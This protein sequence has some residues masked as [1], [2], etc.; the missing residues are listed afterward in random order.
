MYLYPIN[1]MDV[2]HT[3]EYDPPN[4]LQALIGTHSAY[5]C[6]LHEDVTLRQQLDSLGVFS[7]LACQSSLEERRTF[8]VLPSGPMILCRLFTN[9]SLFETVFPI[10][11]M[12]HATASSSILTAWVTLTPRASNLIRSRALRIMYGSYV[13]RVVRT[14]MEPRTKSRVHATPCPFG[15]LVRLIKRG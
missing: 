6:P 4:L 5:S 9:R 2:L 11:I 12:S 10:L 1:W 7:T 15:S 14:N 3:I 8:K 13:L